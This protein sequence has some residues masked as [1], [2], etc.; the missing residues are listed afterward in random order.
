METAPERFMV[1]VIAINQ[2][3]HISQISL[4]KRASVFLYDTSLFLFRS[5]PAASPLPPHRERF[6]IS[7]AALYY[8]CAAPSLR[9]THSSLRILTAIPNLRTMNP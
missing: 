6:Y 9:T 5:F 7:L 2:I 3:K 4:R 1:R 8:L